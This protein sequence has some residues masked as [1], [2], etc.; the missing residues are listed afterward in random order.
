MEL[1]NEEYV[2]YRIQVKRETTK[3]IKYL[4]FLDDSKTVSFKELQLVDADER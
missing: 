2:F 3:E 4:L 1:K